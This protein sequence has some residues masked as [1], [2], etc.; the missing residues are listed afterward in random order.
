MEIGTGSGSAVVNGRWRRFSDWSTK[1]P[2]PRVGCLTGLMRRASRISPPRRCSPL[3]VQTATVIWK[4][5]KVG[6]KHKEECTP[7]EFAPSRFSCV[8]VMRAY[9][10]IFAFNIS[11]TTPAVHYPCM[12]L[13]PMSDNTSTFYEAVDHV[14][15]LHLPPLTLTSV[16]G[17]A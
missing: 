4:L 7:L 16:R 6:D 15:L 13:A 2:T 3:Q 9:W 1:L 12:L 8:R 17:Y 5:R 10:A 11:R 14:P